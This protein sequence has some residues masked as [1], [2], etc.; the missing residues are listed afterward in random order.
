MRNTSN[1][2]VFQEILNDFKTKL[3]KRGYSDYEINQNIQVVLDNYDRATLLSDVNKSKQQGIP[4]VFVIKYN[5]GIRK[6]KQKLL[7]YWHILQKEKDTFS[8]LPIVSYKRN[9]NLGDMLT[10]S[11]VK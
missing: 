2:D 3:R 11:I 4:L 7:K 5:S 1:A 9:Q 6:I 8:V 10:S